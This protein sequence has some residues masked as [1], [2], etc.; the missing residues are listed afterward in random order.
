MKARV[1]STVGVLLLC[2]ACGKSEQSGGPV[3]APDAGDKDNGTFETAD[4]I[5]AAP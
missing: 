3:P 5:D 2:G 4:A 1:V